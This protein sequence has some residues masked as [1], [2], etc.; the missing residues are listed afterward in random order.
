MHWRVVLHVE[1]YGVS[2]AGYVVHVVVHGEWVML[3]MATTS[4]LLGMTGMV[5]EVW[6]HEQC[7]QHVRV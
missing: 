6:R 3:W 7:V 5:Q 4:L 2:S 1:G